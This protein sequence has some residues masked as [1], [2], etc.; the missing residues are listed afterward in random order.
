MRSFKGCGDQS[1]RYIY[2][3]FWDNEEWEPYMRDKT[4]EFKSDE[5]SANSDDVF[6]PTTG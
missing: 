5:S 3:I 6:F 2:G 1:Y 4:A